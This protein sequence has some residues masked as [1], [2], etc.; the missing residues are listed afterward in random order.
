MEFKTKKQKDFCTGKNVPLDRNITTPFANLISWK[1]STNDMIKFAIK[2]GA[3]WN[4]GGYEMPFSLYIE[5]DDFNLDSLKFAIKTGAKWDLKGR[6]PFQT[7][8]K[9]KTL[10]FE[11]LKYA[12][13]TDAK[14]DLKFH[15]TP[16]SDLVLN[17]NTDLKMIKF[18]L[19]TGAKIENI[20]DLLISRAKK[21]EVRDYLMKLKKESLK[22]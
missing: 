7:L 1:D 6:N 22:K 17:P 8:L 16:F 18:A 13:E 12:V 5:K 20:S 21:E 9:K 4:I 10:T 11:M 14:W 2:T 3:N 19:K 15:Y